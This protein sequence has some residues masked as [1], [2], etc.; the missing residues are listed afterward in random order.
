M[1]QLATVRRRDR[2]GL[3][4]IGFLQDLMSY[5]GKKKF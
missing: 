4:L 2:H 3:T 5:S 1:S